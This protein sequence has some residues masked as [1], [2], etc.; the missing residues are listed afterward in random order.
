MAKW[1]NPAIVVVTLVAL[2]T[3][4]LIPVALRLYVVTLSVAAQLGTAYWTSCGAS[5]ALRRVLHRP[6]HRPRDASGR[7]EHFPLRHTHDSAFQAT[8]F[9]PPCRFIRSEV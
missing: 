5:G 6:T 1:I 3:R 8:N 7:M 9:H 4:S 2:P